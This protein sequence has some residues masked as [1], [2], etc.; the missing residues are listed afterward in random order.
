[1]MQQGGGPTPPP[2]PYDAEIEYLASNGTAYI[3]TGIECTGDL[4]VQCEIY[5]TA[6]TGNSICGGLN[7]DTDTYLAHCMIPNSSTHNF[8][9][10]Q[11]SSASPAS[12]HF[13]SGPA[14]N[15]WHE[16]HL[17]GDTGD[18]K[19]NSSGGA[20]TTGSVTPVSGTR[21]TGKSYGLFARIE[22][23]GSTSGRTS[24]WRWCKLLRG[25]VLLRDFIPVRVGTVGYMYDRVSGTLFG[26][27]G[28]G[29][30]T[31]GN[32]K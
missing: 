2:P 1:M 16:F 15:T 31:L 7:N 5:W 20:W 4:S 25:G 19:Y 14:R 17:D 30:F 21:T 22:A 3:D 28:G 10:W 26:N 11:T 24:Y 9:W 32:D 29:S 13:N 8:Y 27:A 23:D 12:I 18:W 6:Q